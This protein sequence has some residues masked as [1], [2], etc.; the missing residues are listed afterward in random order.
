MKIENLERG[1][2]IQKQLKSFEE[3]LNCF[4]YKFGGD[5]ETLLDNPIS[6]NP[7]LMLEFDDYSNEGDRSI[8]PIPNVLSDDLIDMI[9]HGIILNIK[10]LES[11]FID[12]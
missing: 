3:A 4:E 8:I 7:K 12:L 10:S 5:G 6:T 2:E 1:N 11:E 9:K